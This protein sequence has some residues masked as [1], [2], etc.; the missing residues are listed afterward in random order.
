M[1]PKE[2]YRIIII[3]LIFREKP[4]RRE[5]V[6]F[7]TSHGSWIVLKLC[8]SY[9]VV[10]GCAFGACWLEY[11]KSWCDIAHAPNMFSSGAKTCPTGFMQWQRRRINNRQTNAIFCLFV[12]DLSPCRPTPGIINNLLSPR[13]GKTTSLQVESLWHGSRSHHMV[14]SASV[15]A[16]VGFSSWPRIN[17][18]W[19]RRLIDRSALGLFSQDFKSE[20]NW[21]K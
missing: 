12:Y 10:C 21:W 17:G 3:I 8:H 5:I 18:D 15:R 1:E 9:I 2:I 20:W 4:N 19:P 6:M 13:A 14:I 7:H 16:F 11:L